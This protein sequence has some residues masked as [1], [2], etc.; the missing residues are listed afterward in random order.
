MEGVGFEPTKAR[1][2][3]FTVCSLWPLG[4]PS[5][6][7]PSFLL[8]ARRGLFAAPPVAGGGI[9][10]RDLLITNQLLYQLSYTGKHLISLRSCSLLPRVSSTETNA[11][12][13][14][15]TPNNHC[16]HARTLPVVQRG[17]RDVLRWHRARQ[18][19]VLRQCWRYLTP[20]SR[21]S[22]RLSAPP[23]KPNHPTPP[24]Q[25]ALGAAQETWLP[26]LS[27]LLRGRRR[28]K[29]RPTPGGELPRGGGCQACVSFTAPLPTRCRATS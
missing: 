14:N 16:P 10:T 28:G 17:S 29:V 8:F 22:F 1:A 5:A 27:R 6:R 12:T 9:R 24:R 23:C 25:A 26:A 3:R 20:P 18:D 4:Y 2:G 21:L 7:S 19:L 13:T 11:S 15:G